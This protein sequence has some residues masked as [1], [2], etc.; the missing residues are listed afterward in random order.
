MAE[1]LRAHGSRLPPARSGAVSHPNRALPPDLPV[2]FDEPSSRVRWR[3]LK[4]VSQLALSPGTPACAAC[5]STSLSC[6]ISSI[7]ANNSPGCLVILSSFTSALAVAV[8][9]QS[10]NPT[11]NQFPKGMHDL[12]QRMLVAPKRKTRME[13]SRLPCKRAV[14]GARRSEGRC[15]HA[16]RA[17]PDGRQHRHDTSLLLDVPEGDIGGHQHALNVLAEGNWVQILPEDYVCGVF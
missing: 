13:G 7:G 11:I 14:I 9:S 17:S 12:T 1:M 5:F 3:C 15:E 10:A 4:I 6:S 8:A 16:K 2:H